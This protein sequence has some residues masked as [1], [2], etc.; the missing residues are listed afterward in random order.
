MVQLKIFT[1]T[2]LTQIMKMNKP[3]TAAFAVNERD[4]SAGTLEL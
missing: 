3:R 4:D 2:K 1:K